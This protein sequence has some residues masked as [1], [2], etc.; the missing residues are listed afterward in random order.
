MQD[1]IAWNDLALFA[2][3]A[4][5]GTLAR[6]AEETGISVA[7]LSRRMTALEARMGR[8]LFRHGTHGYAATADG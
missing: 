5:T 1:P 2:A 7:T 3:V 6:A 4:R 8:R